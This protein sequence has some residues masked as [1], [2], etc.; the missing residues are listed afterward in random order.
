MR[1]RNLLSLLLTLLVASATFAQTAKIK[2]RVMDTSGSVM[3]GVQVKLYQEDKVVQE[4]VTSPSGDFEIAINPGDYKLEIA[5]PDFTTY[6]EMVKVTSDM[7]PLAV[8]MELATFSQNV[9]VTE[10]RTELSID[11]DASLS[12]T[13]LGRDFIDALPDDEDELATYLQQIAG[14]RGGAGGNTSFIIDGFTGGRIPPKDQIQEIRIS[15]SPFSAEFSGIGYGRTEIITRAG[16]GDFRGQMNFQFRDESLNGRNPF[17]VVD[18][19][20]AKRPPYQA[21]NFNTNFSGPIIRNKLSLNLQARHNDNENSDIIRATTVNPDGTLLQHYD[22]FVAPNHNRGMN[23]RTQLAINKNNTLYTNFNYQKQ[24][25]RNQGLGQNGSFTLLERASDRTAHN[26]EFQVRES[27][28]INTK[29]VHEVRFEYSHDTNSQT[30][31]TVAAAVNVLDTFNSGGGQNKNS[32]KNHETEFGNLLMYSGTKWTVKLG[33]QGV[34]RRDHS[35]SENNF[36]GSWT[37]SSLNDYLCVTGFGCAAG[38]ST[39]P[40]QF[41]R[42][43]GDPRLDVNQFEFA[44]FIQND[45]KVTSKFN[46]SFGVRFEDQTNISDHNNIDP[47]MGFAYQLAK[48]TVIRGGAGVFHDRFS[49][50]TVEQLLRLDGTRQSQIIVR[51]PVGYPL[52]PEGAV[53]PPSSLRTRSAG[54][55]NPYNLN[56]SLSLE[57]AIYKSWGVTLSW[58]AQRGIHLY[59]SRNINAPLPNTGLRPDPSQGNIYQLE[60]T[61]LSKSNNFTIGMRNQLRGRIQAQMFGSYTLGYT[62]NDTDG[63]F[64]LPVNSYDMRSEWGRSP[65]DTRHRF[66]TGMQI[67]WPWGV[68]TTTQVNWSSSRPYNITTGQ[69][70][71]ADSTINDRPTFAALC[72][73]ALIS[74]I[75]GVNCS[76]PSDAVIPR[77]LGNGPGQFNITM[78][79]QKVV[80]L[81][82]GDSTAPAN[83]AGNTGLNGVNNFLPPQRGGGGFPGGGDFGGQ[84]GGLG[85]QRGGGDF[86]GQ[87]GGNRGGGGFGGNRGQNGGFNQNNNGPTVTFQMQVQ[88]LLNHTQLNSYSGTMTSPF[89]G[90]ASSARN[91][92]QVEVGLRLNF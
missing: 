38:A 2:G 72:S 18:G 75:Q 71:N 46:L 7:S 50:G 57:Q 86:G 76:N 44:S 33:S 85:G 81:K 58:D 59:R 92:R 66:N 9:E 12:T 35:L 55:A 39:T 8:T 23:A 40:L 19:A 26:A 28:I 74:S 88:N 45:F 4:G 61:G 51:N 64:S 43:F 82:K 69:D 37:F 52:I 67:R 65:Q 87:R 34:V 42:T 25:N 15:N 31:H 1:M 83:R 90:K 20:I 6:T 16:T 63:A 22:P 13:V 56:Q 84:R 54:L 79:V 77:N 73:S 89:F 29:L 14:T 53:L 24:D 10:T 11:S 41:T 78:N 3:P 62:K 91:P 68:S 70:N 47:R 36:T 5:A 80:R 48:T 49:E 30:P 17:N 60:S 32:T 27:S 21:R